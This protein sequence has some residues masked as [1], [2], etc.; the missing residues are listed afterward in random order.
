MKN[1]KQLPKQQKSKVKQTSGT[2][3]MDKYIYIQGLR[4]QKSV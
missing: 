1:V 4:R 3:G 2:N